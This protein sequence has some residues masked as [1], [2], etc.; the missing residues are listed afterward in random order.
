MPLEV[1]GKQVGAPKYHRLTIGQSKQLYANAT[2][3]KIAL[4][5]VLR[6]NEER[7]ERYDANLAQEMD[8]RI[9]VGVVISDT[10]T[11]RP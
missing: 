7:R 1:D 8:Q 4:L 10:D 9:Q 11:Q 5:K 6:Q 2:R 3:Q